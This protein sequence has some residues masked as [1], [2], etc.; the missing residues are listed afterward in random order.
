ML[1]DIWIFSANA[2]T[3]V[4]VVVDTNPVYPYS[5]RAGHT[6]VATTDLTS[7]IVFGGITCTLMPIELC[8]NLNYIS[9]PDAS[10]QYIFAVNDLRCYSL[11]GL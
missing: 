4:S 7:M 9:A 2:W 1:D 10:D 5:R 6:A 8:T 11:S 3:R